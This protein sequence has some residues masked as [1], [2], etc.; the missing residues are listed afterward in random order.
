[1]GPERPYTIEVDVILEI[2]IEQ[3]NHQGEKK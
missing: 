2:R 1:M 3:A